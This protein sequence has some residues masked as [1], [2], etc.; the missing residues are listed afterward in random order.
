MKEKEPKWETTTIAVSVHRS[1]Q[2]ALFG[3]NVTHVLLEDE[4]GGCFV[5]LKQDDIQM[6]LDID[7]LVEILRVAKEMQ[8]NYRA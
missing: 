5:I 8:K 1:D 2:N 7:E 4:A 3:E 6:R